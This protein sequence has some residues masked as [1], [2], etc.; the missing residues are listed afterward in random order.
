MNLPIELKTRIYDHIGTVQKHLAELPTDEQW[1]ILQALET[2]IHDAL[3]ARANGNPDLAVLEAI[4]AE[5]DPP[6]SYGPAPLMAPPN[7]TSFSSGW[8]I[9]FFSSIA[10]LCLLFIAI[11]LADPFSSHWMDGEVKGGTE[12]SA[13]NQLVQEGVGLQDFAIGMTKDALIQKH[14]APQPNHPDW[15]MRWDTLPFMDVIITEEDFC[16]EVRFNRGFE[17]QTFA[18]IKQDSS[19][20]DARRAYGAAERVWTRNSCVIAEW[21]SKGIALWTKGGKVTQIIIR[22]PMKQ[23]PP[24]FQNDPRVLGQWESIDFVADAAQFDPTK[25]SWKDDLFLKEL[26]FL[27]NGKSTASWSWTKGIIL[28]EDSWSR[29]E[30]KQIGSQTYL[31]LEWMSGDVTSRGEYPRYYVFTKK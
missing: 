6:E 21:P 15:L 28:E 2:H 7:S 4:I 20:Q 17:G 10:I 11:W 31:F 16:R 14:G 24:I 8:K 27:S 25:P 1:E 5:M 13:S 3:E 9:L 18:G 26:T 30:F 23:E 22:K 19:F 29:Y 12:A